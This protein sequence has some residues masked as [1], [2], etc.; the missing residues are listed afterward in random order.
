MQKVWRVPI[1]NVNFTIAVFFDVTDLGEQGKLNR[2][3]R[4]AIFRVQIAKNPINGTKFV[5]SF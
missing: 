5:F 3:K 1:N 2:V 4:R